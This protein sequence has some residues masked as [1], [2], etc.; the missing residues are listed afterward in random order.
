MKHSTVRDQL[1]HRTAFLV[2]AFAAAPR[3]D[4][5]A[6]V[7]HDCEECALLRDEFAPHT[8]WSLPV[9]TVREHHGDLPLFTHEAF[10]Y[11]LPAYLAV[12]LTP[13]IS[14]GDDLVCEFVLYSLYPSSPLAPPG[15]HESRFA[16]F[17]PAELQAILASIDLIAADPRHEYSRDEARAAVAWWRERLH[18]I[19][20]SPGAV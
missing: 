3:P 16:A 8:P 18:G 11:F 6:L 14:L 19:P 20:C 9:A 17:Q 2:P 7:G 13:E 15:R 1:T 10:R 4:V 5:S 12:A